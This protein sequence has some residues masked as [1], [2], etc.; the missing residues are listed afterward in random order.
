MTAAASSTAPTAITW[1]GDDLVLTRTFEAPRERV[2]QAWTQA[3][4]FARW[5]GPADATLPFCELDARP[6]GA[7]RW[8]HRFAGGGGDVWIGGVFQEVAPP[9]RLAFTCFFSD[10]SGAR[11]QRPG[12]PAEMRI[13]VDFAE[14]GG[15]TRVTIRHAGLPGDHGEVQGWTEGLDRLEALLSDA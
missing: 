11:V 10:P 6:G 14:E 4:H 3:E 7:L 8:C 13:A 5:W 2:F 1:D 12:Y 15:G 9:E